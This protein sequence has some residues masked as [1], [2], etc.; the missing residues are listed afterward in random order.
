[1]LSL[2]LIPL[3]FFLFPFYVS[4]HPSSFISAV[5]IS[6]LRSLVAVAHSITFTVNRIHSNPG[7]ALAWCAPRKKCQN[8]TQK[9]T[10]LTNDRNS[11]ATTLDC[12]SI[13]VRSALISHHQREENCHS[14]RGHCYVWTVMHW[15]RMSCQSIIQSRARM[16]LVE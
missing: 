9:N 5:S 12:C 2:F 1:M 14:N 11:I 6:R 13:G 10:Q 7:C 3:G 15:T 8:T 16:D 4:R